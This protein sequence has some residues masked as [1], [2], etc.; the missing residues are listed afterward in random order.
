M[1]STK[2]IIIFLLSLLL[3]IQGC[4]GILKNPTK[5]PDYNA[6]KDIKNATSQIDTANKDINNSASTIEEK[7]QNIRSEAGEAESKLTEDKK[8]IQPHLDTIKKDSDIIVKESAN[9]QHSS[10]KILTAQDLLNDAKNKISNMESDLKKIESERDKA[11][12]EMNKAIE[13]KN[14]QLQRLLRY[15][16]VACIVGTGIFAIAFFL[17]GNTWG[18]MG[19]ASCAVVMAIAIFVHAYLKYLVLIG[20]GIFLALIILLI[21]NIYKHKKA[22]NEVVD[23]VEIAQDNLDPAK[24]DA[25]FG[26]PGETGIM[27]TIQS[28]D[29][30]KLVKQAKQ[31]MSKLWY[32]AKTHKS[33]GQ[34]GTNIS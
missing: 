30:M 18:L 32:Y 33:N 26:G 29:T 34:A 3:F 27:D 5:I 1:K 13:E 16:I 8:V 11:I 12:S 20:G 31:G 14:S 10:N 7:A 22:F 6:G 23:T 24:R 2:I 4:D 28:K 25:I 21:Y 19:A 15:I 17:Y 9:I